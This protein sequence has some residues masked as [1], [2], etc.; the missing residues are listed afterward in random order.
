[1]SRFCRIS[2]LSPAY[3]ILNDH[4]HDL[5]GFIEQYDLSLS[6][7]S[8]GPEVRWKVFSNMMGLKCSEMPRRDSDPEA[9]PSC[10]MHHVKG[11]HRE[12]AHRQAEARANGS[13]KI[14]EG[15]TVHHAKEVAGTSREREE[16]AG[17][18]ENTDQTIWK[19]T[20]SDNHHLSFLSSR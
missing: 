3:K 1:M 15:S 8:P 6:C 12:E 17:P 11:G 16:A 5:S 18:L 14:L 2:S 7:Y 10:L 13:V 19:K 9:R 20:K 4:V